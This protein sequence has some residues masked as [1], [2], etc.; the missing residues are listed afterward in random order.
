MAVVNLYLLNEKE[1]MQDL[2]YLWFA[3]Y[4]MQVIA[5]ENFRCINTFGKYELKRSNICFFSVH[6]AD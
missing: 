4:H 3:I 6:F 5:E 2:L 1:P